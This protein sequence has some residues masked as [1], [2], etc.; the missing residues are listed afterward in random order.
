MKTF[1]EFLAETQSL[2]ESR[3]QDLKKAKEPEIKKLQQKYG[4]K[5]STKIDGG[6]E[7]VVTIASS[8]IDFFGSLKDK[9]MQSYAEE[10]G[11]YNFNFTHSDHAN[12]EFT[13]IAAE[14]LTQLSKILLDDKKSVYNNDSQENI[15]NFYSRIDI[16]NYKHPYILL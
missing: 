3:I 4:A 11:Y 8:K 6:S 15:P 2:S 16:G 9:G 14:F 10:R 12:K 13:G 1:K 7:I 5:V